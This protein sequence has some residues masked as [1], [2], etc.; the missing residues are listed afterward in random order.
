MMPKVDSSSILFSKMNSYLA[1]RVFL[2]AIELYSILKN[3]VHYK[4]ADQKKIGI[5]FSSPNIAKNMHV[6][7][8]RSTIIGETFSRMFEFIGHDVKRINHV[9]DW[10]TQFGMLI[11]MLDDEYPDFMESTPSVG[12][13]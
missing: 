6:G 4:V 5:D 8:L 7:H 11:A 13:L 12:D 2:Y 9:G 3:G 10:G 1:V